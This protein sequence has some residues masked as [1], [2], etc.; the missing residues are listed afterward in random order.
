MQENNN[1]EHSLNEINIEG[2]EDEK[3]GKND[4]KIK[5]ME[6]KNSPEDIANLSLP[7]EPIDFSKNSYTIFCP[8]CNTRC[9]TRMKKKRG[10]FLCLST[11]VLCLLPPLCLVP[12]CSKKFYDKLHFCSNCGIKIGYHKI[13]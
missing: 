6:Q 3:Q 8:Y 7:D 2:Q 1:W 4:T 10:R 12:I 5:L 11:F 9:S 13:F